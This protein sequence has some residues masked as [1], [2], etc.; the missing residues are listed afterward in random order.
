MKIV[1]LVLV[2]VTVAWLFRRARRTSGRRRAGTG[3]NSEKAMRQRYSKLL[4]M[5]PKIA[6]RET[7]RQLAELAESHPLLTKRQRLELLI[8][9]VE[10]ARR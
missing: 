5:S 6:A 3:A 2:V 1:L 8:A 10:R 7:D 9:R 4:A